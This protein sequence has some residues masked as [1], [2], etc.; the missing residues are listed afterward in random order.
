[1]G[2]SQP[3]EDQIIKEV[4]DYRV[5]EEDEGVL[6]HPQYALLHHPDNAREVS[7]A[8]VTIGWTYFFPVGSKRTLR[9]PCLK[10]A[11][12]SSTGEPAY[13]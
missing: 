4:L 7:T 1:L 11:K 6:L 3:L 2:Q 8:T 12:K 5:P 9:Q 10:Y 13:E